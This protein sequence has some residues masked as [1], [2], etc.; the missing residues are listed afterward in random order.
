MANEWTS[1]T[2]EK[3]LHHFGKLNEDGSPVQLALSLNW[4]CFQ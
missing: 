4:S 1:S 3:K 2:A